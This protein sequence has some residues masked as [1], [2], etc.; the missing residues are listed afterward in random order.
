[1][2][3]GLRF[4]QRIDFCHTQD[5]IVDPEW[6]TNA[7]N[8]FYIDTL[9]NL[10]SKTKTRVSTKGKSVHPSKTKWA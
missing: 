8:S 2:L 9:R 1:M 3:I 6:S 7:I 10:Y 5:E 4:S